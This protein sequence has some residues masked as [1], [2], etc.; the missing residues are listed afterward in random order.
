M[1]RFGSPPPSAPPPQCRSQWQDGWGRG[2]ALGA[3]FLQRGRGRGELRGLRLHLPALPLGC[4]ECPPRQEAVGLVQV[5][6]AK[7][8]GG[9]GGLSLQGGWGL[10]PRGFAFFFFFSAPFFFFFSSRFYLE[11][12]PGRPRRN[13][14]H[15]PARRGF[16]PKGRSRAASPASLCSA[17]TSPGLTRTLP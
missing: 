14:T 15:Q 12:A 17:G 1:G 11:A 7:G 9:V 2:A 16:G 10:S 13:V 5:G 8:P 4:A 6:G 3:R